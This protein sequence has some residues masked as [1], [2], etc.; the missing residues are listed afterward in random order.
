LRPHA[1]LQKNDFDFKDDIEGFSLRKGDLKVD[2]RCGIWSAVWLNDLI[3]SRGEKGIAPFPLGFSQDNALSKR[4]I[5][6]Q[7]S[8][9]LASQFDG[10]NDFELDCKAADVFASTKVELGK[11]GSKLVELKTAYAMECLEPTPAHQLMEINDEGGSSINLG[12][13]V[14]RAFYVAVSLRQFKTV[15]DGSEAPPAI[16]ARFIEG[17]RYYWTM[18]EKVLYLSNGESSK[19]GLPP[20]HALLDFG[21]AL[22]M[23][24][25]KVASA[26]PVG[27]PVAGDLPQAPSVD[28]SGWEVVF[29]QFIDNP[30]ATT[31][32]VLRSREIRRSFKSFK[33]DDE[34][35][36]GTTRKYKLTS[37]VLDK[38]SGP[39]LAATFQEFAQAIKD[40]AGEN[41]KV[42]F[43]LLMKLEGQV[44]FLVTGGDAGKFY[45]NSV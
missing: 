36:H 19:Y 3:S 25:W 7:F 17:E 21:I 38:F 20:N 24:D 23:K 27:P 22:E 28:V 26:P 16:W 9:V 10:L 2:I 1:L 32:G 15:T 13:K 5:L 6:G 37:K 31:F 18:R 39:E 41:L 33:G 30:N 43:C 29:K 4:G 12:V 8:S 42:Q 35:N 11:R 34:Y 14:G 44:K 45:L 40:A